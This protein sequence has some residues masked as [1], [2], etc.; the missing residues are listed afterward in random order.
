VIQVAI[1]LCQSIGTKISSAE[2]GNSLRHFLIY[3][4]PTLHII[5][6]T[7][8]PMIIVDQQN[9]KEIVERIDQN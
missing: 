8:D 5:F 3:V 7:A 2:F 9:E 1:S 4:K 6:A